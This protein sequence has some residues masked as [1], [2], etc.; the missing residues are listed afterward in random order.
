MRHRSHSQQ[1][2]HLILSSAALWGGAAILQLHAR[3][4]DQT[5]EGAS[6]LAMH[7]GTSSRTRFLSVGEVIA[8]QKNKGTLR[9]LRHQDSSHPADQQ[10]MRQFFQN[11]RQKLALIDRQG[12][13]I[14]VFACSRIQY[15]QNRQQAPVLLYGLFESIDPAWRGFI[16]VGLQA[17]VYLPV[18]GYLPPVSGNLA[19][20]GRQVDLQIRHQRD[21]KLM[22]Y[23]PADIVIFGQDSDSTADNFNPWFQNRSPEHQT[24]LKAFYMDKYEVTNRE[25]LHFCR[26]SHHPLPGAWQ[27]SGSYPPGTADHPVHIVSY[28]DAQAYADW[29]GK[30]LPSELEW[31]LAAR[32]GYMH[33]IQKGNDYRE[34]AASPPVWPIGDDYDQQRCN[35]L[36]SGYGHT[37]SVFTLQDMSPLGLVG[38][39][40]NAR[41]WTS[42]WYKAY[43]GSPG[44]AARQVFGSLYRVIRGGS[45]ADSAEYARA[46]FRDYGGFPSLENDQSAGFRLVMDP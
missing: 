13:Q 46:D 29:S 20:R 27:Q 18:A 33:L 22:L 8:V 37:R 28:A 31:E 43:P 19:G 10:W 2:A 25:Y 23:I 32:G 30:R 4:L 5:N 42:S 3:P 45:F 7:V 35:T 17:G 11:P 26:R 24:R 12:Q 36:E 39:C 15:L 1:L 41:E 9:L 44:G 34:V 16:Q 38:M 21:R 40:G 14:A 6:S